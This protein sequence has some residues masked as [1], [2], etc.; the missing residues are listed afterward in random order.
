MRAP[1]LIALSVVAAL[2]AGCSMFYGSQPAQKPNVLPDVKP[3]AT[4]HVRWQGSVGSADRFVFSPAVTADRVYAAGARGE[5]V[6]FD[7]ASGKQ[8]VRFDAKSRLTGGVGANSR[9]ITV[10]TPAGEVLAFDPAGKLLWKAQLTSEVLSA[11]QI[12]LGNVV[13][14]SG[15]G[16]IF[17][18][19]GNTGARL[20]VYQRSLP[21]LTIRTAVGV[22]AYS[23]GVFAGFA[24]GRLVAIAAANGGVVWEAAIAL[25]KGS[26]ELERIAD[27]SSLPV[28]DGRQ[29]CAAAYQ[30]RVACVDLLTGN[31]IWAR[32]I[33]SVAGIA[34][35]ASN[36]YVSDDKSAVLA[37]DKGTGASLWKQDKLN[38]RVVSGPAIAGRYVAVGDYQGYV[39]FLS[40]TDGSFVARIATDG[41]AITAQPVAMGNGVLVQTVKG[42]VFFITVE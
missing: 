13:A 7:A 25:P 17:Q 19:D 35:D 33:S 20:W 16:R 29:I 28:V 30:G 11:P 4:A 15:D 32:E 38:G 41:S 42:G 40:P 24:G 8:V 22:T 39:H 10:G 14:R 21:P 6:G 1:T 26:T 2:A 36:V 18:F 34:I 9:L 31:S 37:F 12:V 23:D 27:I 3:S 5:I